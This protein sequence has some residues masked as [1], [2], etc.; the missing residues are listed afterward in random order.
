MLAQWVPTNERAKIGTLVYA[1]GQIGTVVGNAVSGTLID[2]TQS[3]ESVFYLFGGVGLLWYIIWSLIC[4]SSPAEHP[5]ISDKERTF[6]E[7]EI[8]K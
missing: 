3:W 4:Y 7:K 5:F 8:G 1:G 2:Y 6:L